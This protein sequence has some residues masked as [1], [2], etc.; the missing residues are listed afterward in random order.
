MIGMPSGCRHRL[1]ALQRL[2]IVLSGDVLRQACLDADHDVAVAFDGGARGR[3]VRVGEI[4]QVAVRDDALSRHVDE[5]AHAVRRGFGDGN[6]GVDAVCAGR[7]GVHERRDA[8]GETKSAVFFLA[9]RMSVNVDE[10]GDDELPR[11]IDG[12]SRGSRRDVVLHRG[13]LSVF[14]CDVCHLVELA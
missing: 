14:D 2:E 3:G 6:D 12:L 11:G 7:P 1:R 8:V 9:A 10:P 5:D 4:H 13:N